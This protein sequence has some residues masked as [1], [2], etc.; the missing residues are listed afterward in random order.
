MQRKLTPLERL[1]KE[2]PYLRDTD[3]QN[4]LDHVGGDVKLAIEQLKPPGV[5]PPAIW[6]R[7]NP[8]ESPNT[9]SNDVVISNPDSLSGLWNWQNTPVIPNPSTVE[10]YLPRQPVLTAVPA[11]LMTSQ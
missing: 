9:R 6:E 3:L 1:R 11:V 7:R 8:S 4:E 10:W 2:F 5:N